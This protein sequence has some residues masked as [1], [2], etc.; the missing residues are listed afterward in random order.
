[1]QPP[2]SLWRL[3]DSRSEG[4]V[5]RRS[6]ENVGNW[7]RNAVASW[8]YKDEFQLLDSPQIMSPYQDAIPSLDLEKNEERFLLAGGADAT[9]SIFDLSKWGSDEEQ[10]QQ[11]QQQLLSSRN[12]MI[13]HHKPI[14]RSNRATT[15]Q[16]TRRNL[17]SVPTGHAAA[18]VRAQWYRVDTGACVSVAVDGSLLV[19][20][21]QFL[22]PVIQWKPYAT[23][24]S[25]LD[26]S[27]SVGGRSESLLAVG[28][29]HEDVIKLVD[30]RSGASS[31]SFHGHLGGITVV[32]WASTTDV[33]LAS[34]GQDGTIRLWDIRK[35]G[36]RSCLSILNRDARTV[37]ASLEAASTR[38][39]TPTYQH[40]Q[41][42]QQV[43][44][45]SNKSIKTSGD[46]V[47]PL[48]KRVKTTL[49]MAPNNYGSVESTGIVSHGGPVSAL[50]FCPDGHGLVSTGRDG[51]MQVWD[52]RGLGHAVPIRFSR[53][54]TTRTLHV[55][56]PQPQ[57]Q[58]LMVSRQAKRICLSITQQSAT[59]TR[60]WLGHGC[61]AVA[62]SMERGGMPLQVLEGHLGE[63]TAVEPCHDTFRLLTAG[64]DGMILAWGKPHGTRNANT[65][66]RQ[67]LMDDRD[68]W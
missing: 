63:V 22:T 31:H 9:L 18:I 33:V 17:P 58:P 65:H 27:P 62:Y 57:Q 39:Y 8:H 16:P 32:Q 13:R 1:M 30:L 12:I 48:G 56:Q 68:S 54:S 60:I 67:R 64:Q 29:Y 11:Q 25:C 61:Q 24:C 2:S 38:P 44:N 52:L 15:V 4:R 23:S 5:G 14:A 59:C 53:P 19:W 50:A 34:G 43:V 7:F 35:S 45:P 51:M 41:R 6:K 47:M 36:S 49:D 37:T 46:L 3:V 26:L 55:T 42:P 40:L 20:D 66:G 10:Q 21:T 28:S